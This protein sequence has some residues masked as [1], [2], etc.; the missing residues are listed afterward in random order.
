MKVKELASKYIEKAER[1]L[2]EISLSN[3][4][5]YINEELVKMVIEEA[6]RYLKDAKFYLGVQR[7]ETSLAAV[8]YCEGLLDALRMLGL[9]EFSW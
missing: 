5:T 9:V 4:P 7:F 6:E 3:L 8:S 1:V 2:G